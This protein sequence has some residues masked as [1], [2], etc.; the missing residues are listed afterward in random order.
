MQNERP[1]TL[2]ERRVRASFNPSANHLVDEFKAKSAELIDMC[3]HLKS[4][5]RSPE[6]VR[7]IALAQTHYEDAAMWIVK[8]ATY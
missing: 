7:L 4:E 6:M 2:G 1:Q 5:A 8:A 3:E